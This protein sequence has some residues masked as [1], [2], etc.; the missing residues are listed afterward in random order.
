MP[1][2]SST[3]ATRRHAVGADSHGS[4]PNPPASDPTIAPAVFAAYA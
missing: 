2:T 1:S 3:I 4:S